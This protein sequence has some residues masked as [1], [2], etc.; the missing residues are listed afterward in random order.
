MYY[1]ISTFHSFKIKRMCMGDSILKRVSESD[2]QQDTLIR[3]SSSHS[4]GA[5]TRSSPVPVHHLMSQT[6]WLIQCSE[7]SLW[8]PK[9]SLSECNLSC[10]CWSEH[11]DTNFATES[12]SLICSVNNDTGFLHFF[13]A[14]HAA[15]T[16]TKLRNDKWCKNPQFNTLSNPK[17]FSAHQIWGWNLQH[18]V[19]YQVTFVIFLIFEMKM[20]LFAEHLQL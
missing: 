11:L 15:C 19:Q 18:K 7:S 2:F 12:T 16:W 1:S 14:K 4:D 17:H 9:W 20:W 10:F 8:S 3:A 6:Y 5:D 13:A